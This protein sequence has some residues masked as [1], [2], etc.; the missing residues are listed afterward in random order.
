MSKTQTVI[1]AA[2]EG[3]RMKSALPKVL[4]PLKNKPV[5]QYLLDSVRASGI[6]EKPCIV[7]GKSASI[8]K[9]TLGP[10]YEYVFQR[11]RLGTGHALKMCRPFLEKRF[12][13][14]VALYGD[15]PFVTIETLR[16]VQSAHEKSGA[17]IT[18]PTFTIPDFTGWRDM[19][20]YF[21]RVTRNEK[22]T[23][24][25]IIEY[26][27]CTE[28]QKKI[29]ELSPGCFVFDAEWLWKNIGKLTND[30]NQKEYYLVELVHRAV[31]Q[32]KKI[33][34]ILVDSHT[35]LGINTSK[36]L[37]VAERFLEGK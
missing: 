18:V 32:D 8:V 36:Q 13:A 20:Y 26:K 27:D 11:K 15:M 3:K 12:D 1:L 10:S 23:L 29:R 6:S 16:S 30:N 2:G 7:V 37:A 4:I 9:K 24:E 19:F 17:I 25:A 35:A 21:G 31:A 5:I 34:T 14:I 22:G 28:K 33:A